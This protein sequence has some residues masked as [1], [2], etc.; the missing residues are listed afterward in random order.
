VGGDPASRSREGKGGSE[1]GL[2]LAGKRGELL[3]HKGTVF[4]DR[5][6]KDRYLRKERT[7]KDMKRSGPAHL[8]KK[9]KRKKRYLVVKI[10]R[11][12]QRETETFIFDEMEG[13][14]PR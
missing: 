3:E 13:I 12:S 8:G 6:G 4:S 11:S 14:L 5:Q 9:K 2:L 7:R 10:K 1:E